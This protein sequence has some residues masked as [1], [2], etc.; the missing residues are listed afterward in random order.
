[1]IKRTIIFRADGGSIIGMGH[2][3]RT[4]ALA[5]MLKDDFYCIYATQS[6][7][8]YQIKEIESVCQERIDLPS[9]ETHF[10]VFLNLLKDNEIVVLD[11]Y[12]FTTE[13][14]RAIKAKGCKL[15]CV[16]DMHD[17]HFVAD[18]IINHAE[19]ITEFQYSAEKYTAF[20]LGYKFALLRQD[21]LSNF[22]QEITKQYS[23][24]VMMGGA[25]PFNL[26]AKIVSM[27]QPLQFSLPIAVVVG[28]EYNNEYLFK[29]YNNLE[30]FKG[31]ESSKVFQL[32]QVA[33]LGIFPA[34]TVAIEACAARLPFICGYFIDNQKEIYKGIKTNHLAFCIGN[35]LQVDKND[36]VTAFKQ[37]I[38]REIAEGIIQKQKALLDKKSK[39]R[40]IKT[41]NHLWKSESEKLQ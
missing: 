9:D 34:S 2:F 3:I 11:N 1:M 22:S 31:I 30:L 18:L 13:Y 16:D 27:I 17:K 5:E 36:F 14:Q 19:G 39:E 40:F 10:D 8:A 4:L 33:Q 32:M 21:Y 23:C 26:T 6:P 38:Q 25:D 28:A 24:L 12:Y 29:L 7:T 20:C 15:V 35:Y 41:F 37:L